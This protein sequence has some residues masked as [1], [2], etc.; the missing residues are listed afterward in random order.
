[1]CYFVAENGYRRLNKTSPYCTSNLL[2]ARV[3]VIFSSSCFYGLLSTYYCGCRGPEDWRVHVCLLILAMLRNICPEL[4]HRPQ[5]LSTMLDH[6]FC[7]HLP[8]EDFM[9]N[10]TLLQHITLAQH[11]SHTRTQW[12]TW[13]VT[14]AGK[15]SLIWEGGDHAPPWG[16]QKMPSTPHPHDKEKRA[17]T[18]VGFRIVGPVIFSLSQY[19]FR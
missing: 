18:N 13:S 5:L 9:A 7:M 4:P 11:V 14:T 16:V 12:S 17:V 2:K 8:T 3:A 1:M 19:A 10:W 6:T 15:I